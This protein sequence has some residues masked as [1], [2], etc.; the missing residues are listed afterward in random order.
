MEERTVKI[1]FLIQSHNFDQDVIVGNV[2]SSRHE[3]VVVNEGTV[4]QEITVNNTAS[5]LKTNEKSVNLQNL[6]SSSNE[7]IDNEMGIIVDT[8]EDWIQNAILTAFDKNFTPRIELAVW[9]IFAS[10][11]RDATC[12]TAILK[13]GERVGIF[14][15][16]ENV[17]QRKN[18]I[19]LFNTNDETR[20]NNSDE[21]SGL[22][23]PVAHFDQQ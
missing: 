8:V 16:F 13:H 21:V 3:N 1:W 23:V 11:G 14:A 6:E 10:S 7:R 19:H 17:S 20:R 15:S 2:A 18:T 4:D 22:S 9:S 12:V 5:N